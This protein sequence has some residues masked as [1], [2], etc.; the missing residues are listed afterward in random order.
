MRPTLK[1][2]TMNLKAPKAVLLGTSALVCLALSA[3]VVADDFVITGS[4]N[5]TNGTG[6]TNGGT[7]AAIADT[8]IN[9]SDTVSLGVAL[10]TTGTNV[11]IETTGGTNKVTVSEAGSITTG[12]GIYAFGI[13]I[14]GDSNTATVSG[15]IETTGAVALGIYNF[16][17]TNTTT[18]AGSITTAGAYA[19]GIYNLGSTNTT[20][21]SEDGSITTDGTEA[22]GIRNFGDNNKTTISGT[23]K[24]TGARSAALYNITGNGNSFTLNEGATII[25]DIIARDATNNAHEATNS[26]LIFNLGASTSYAYSV[27]GKGE[28][29]G[30]G[31]WIFS[32]L[33]RSSQ[34]V[35]T[36]GTGCDTTITYAGN[37]T[38]NLVTAVGAANAEVQNELQ[39]ITSTSLINSLRLDT[40]VNT[41]QEETTATDVWFDAYGVSTERD[42]STWDTT[43]VVFNADTRGLTIGKPLVLGDSFGLDLVF[44]TSQTDLDVGATKHQNIAAQSF[45]FGVVMTDLA[46]SSNWDV[47]AFGFIGRNSYEGKRKVMNNQVSTG[48]ETVT[49]S[50]S[51]T[52]AL[53]GFDV[54]YTTPINEAVSFK[55]GINANL[56]NEKIGAYSE[57]KYS[58]W[59]AR[60]VSQAA[61][62]I[63]AGL[64]HKRSDLLST[65]VTL[66]AEYSSLLSGEKASYTNNGT[67]T[68]YTDHD[69]SDD[70]ISSVA[71][72]FKYAGTNG[73]SFEGSIKG[74]SSNKGLTSTSAN[75]GLNWAF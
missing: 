14:Y 34:V 72:G 56:S 71:V 49:S 41:S 31:Q 55:G 30:G 57:S 11:G 59:N 65:F 51:G 53:V 40:P 8:A 22:Y 9:G 18:V 15:S 66:G 29:T 74:S 69:A 2:N 4:D 5:S 3:P 13:Y 19:D 46:S 26:K 17:S 16:G 68:S 1:V 39:Y 7:A 54:D 43:G 28:G 12:T 25:G 73:V 60:T 35:T 52:K 47:D 64:T 38:C 45:N 75:F 10:T 42:A 20:T 37:D 23:V 36:S 32:D 50:Y 62:G 6:T 67:A 27:S 44:N 63:S 58:T 70:M 61:S 33:D 21:V 24:A 48:S